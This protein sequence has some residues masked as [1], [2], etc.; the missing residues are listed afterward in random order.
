MEANGTWRRTE[1]S[2]TLSPQLGLKDMDQPQVPTTTDPTPIL[3]CIGV[4]ARHVGLTR[5]KQIDL[6]IF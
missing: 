5:P 3:V 6:L 2:A 1:H 4:R